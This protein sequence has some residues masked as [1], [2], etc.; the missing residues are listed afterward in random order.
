MSIRIRKKIVEKDLAAFSL[1]RLTVS[2][3]IQL[4]K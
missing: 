1:R 2:N 3:S 4:S